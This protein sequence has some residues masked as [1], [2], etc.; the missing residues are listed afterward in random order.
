MQGKLSDFSTKNISNTLIREIK[1]A[2]ESIQTYGSVEIYVHDG[3]VSQISTRNIKK[4]ASKNGNG[5]T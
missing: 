3:V 2:L 4:T 1:K 5:K